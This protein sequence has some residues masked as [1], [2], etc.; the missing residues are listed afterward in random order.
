MKQIFSNKK[1][2]NSFDVVDTVD[3]GV[4]LLGWEV[5]SLKNINISFGGAYVDVRGTSLW[6]IGVKIPTWPGTHLTDKQLNIR[7]RQLLAHKREI[8]KINS[9]AKR[10]GYTIVP[11]KGYINDNGLIKLQIAVVKGRKKYQNKQKIKEREVL[12]ELRRSAKYNR[13]E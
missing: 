8:L 13:Y 5:K 12:Q 2:N 9:F 7:P 1:I 10:P 6:L 3:V 11:L 4:S